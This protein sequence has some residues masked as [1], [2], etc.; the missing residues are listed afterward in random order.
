M[1]KENEKI[2]LTN[3]EVIYFWKTGN[4]SDDTGRADE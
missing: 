1:V 2:Y 4:F 3:Y